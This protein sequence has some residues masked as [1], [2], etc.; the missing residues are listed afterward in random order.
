VDSFD[1]RFDSFWRRVCGNYRVIGVRDRRYLNWRF[2]SRPDASYIRLAA[3]TEE[4]VEG[5]LIFRIAERDGLR[6]GFLVDYLVAETSPSI[7]SQLLD[8]AEQHLLD[9]RVTAI[10]C[11]GAPYP[12]RSTLWRHGYYPTIFRSYTYLS[13]SVRSLDPELREFALPRYWYTSMG[14]GDLDTWL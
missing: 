6:C 5:Y 12:Y 10:V 4:R 9:A 2:V 14:D 1:E 3:I 7:F 11:V 13:S 8:R